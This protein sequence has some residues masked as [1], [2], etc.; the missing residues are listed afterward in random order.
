M[1]LKFTECLESQE[2]WQLTISWFSNLQCTVFGK[3]PSISIGILKW[4]VVG[5]TIYSVLGMQLSKSQ[6]S[7]NYNYLDFKFTVYLD[8]SYAKSNNLLTS[9]RLLDLKFTVNLDCN[10][11]SPSNLLTPCTFLSP[12]ED[13]VTF[14]IKTWEQNSTMAWDSSVSLDST[15]CLGATCY[16]TLKHFF[17]ILHIFSIYVM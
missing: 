17:G 6:K 8:G 7:W 1:D 3:E 14:K 12:T 11:A 5:F 4:P 2:Y 15:E 10:Y 16:S 9:D 13:R